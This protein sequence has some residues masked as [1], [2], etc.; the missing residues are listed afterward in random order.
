MNKF[1]FKEKDRAEFI[2]GKGEVGS[3]IKSDISVLL[4]YYKSLDISKKDAICEVKKILKKTMSS[5]DISER[6]DG[7]IKSIADKSYHKD[8][9]LVHVD[10]VDIYKEELEFINNLDVKY[11]L[12]KILFTLLVYKKVEFEITNHKCNMNYYSDND[13]KRRNLK[14]IYGSTMKLDESV[15]ELSKL[16]LLQN[17]YNSDIK[18]F[19]IDKIA[20]LG[21]TEVVYE[22]NVFE[23]SALYF[24]LYNNR[25]S[26]IK[27]C[28]NCGMMFKPKS[29]AGKYCKNCAKEVKIQQDKGYY[30]NKKP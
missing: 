21:K 25:G 6:Y 26:K 12:K 16:D 20:E 27:P 24:D 30:Y 29:N 19:F 11:S 13:Y 9:K 8:S 28:Q 2:I 7:V 18:L 1:L 5:F 3:Y 23:N 22:V 15:F 10:K 14:L 4:K 17:G